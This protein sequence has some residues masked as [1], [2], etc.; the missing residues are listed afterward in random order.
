METVA[1]PQK[2]KKNVRSA[3]RDF[4]VTE[5]DIMT[6]AVLFYLAAIK[7]NMDLKNDLRMWDDASAAD[8][9]TFERSLA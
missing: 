8:L 4:G 9:A 2:L 1:T 3:A 7:K 5:D 6:N